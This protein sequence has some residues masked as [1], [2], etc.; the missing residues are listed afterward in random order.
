MLHYSL[1]LHIPFLENK[2]FKTISVL[3]VRTPALVRLLFLIKL[4]L[5][6]ISVVL[7]DANKNIL[8]E[9]EN[10]VWG[11]ASSIMELTLHYDWIYRKV[12]YKLLP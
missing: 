3:G 1:R 8:S 9:R 7:T 6:C 11:K 5:V 10:Q 4:I 2:K 12:F